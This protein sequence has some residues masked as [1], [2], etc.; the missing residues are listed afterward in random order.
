MTDPKP[1]RS[2][3]PQVFPTRRTATQYRAATVPEAIAEGILYPGSLHA[4]AG[5][6]KA[7][8]SWLATQLGLCVALGVEFLGRQ[9]ERRRVLYISLDMGLAL[10]KDRIEKIA[11]HLGATLDDEF[12]ETWFS[13]IAPDTA[14]PV[15]VDLTDEGI[16]PLMAERIKEYGAEVV[17][18]DTFYKFVGASDPNDMGQMQVMF[19]RLLDLAKQTGAAIVLLDHTRKNDTDDQSAA[20]SMVGSV[21]KGGSTDLIL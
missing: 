2:R 15:S 13:I 3:P 4:I 9:V 19:G 14:D 11:E 8:K 16:W 10:A 18:L 1:T 21:I 6:P 5:R 7:G 20:L 17:F 12:F